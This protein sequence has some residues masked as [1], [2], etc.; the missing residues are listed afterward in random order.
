MASI[1]ALAPRIEVHHLTR[2]EGH[3]NIIVDIRDG[4]IQVCDLE[5]VEAPRYFEAMLRGRP[6]DQVPQLASRICG[7]CA[8]SHTTAS[9]GAIESAL[10]VQISPQTALLRHLNLCAEMLDSHLLHVY[11]LVAPDLIGTESVI[12]LALEKPELVSRALR[13][14]H[15]AGQICA[16]VG[17]RH[18]HPIAMTVGGFTHVPSEAELQALLC[19]LV[20]MRSDIESTVE[21]FAQLSFPSFERETEYVALQKEGGYGLEGGHIVSSDGGCWPVEQYRD[22]ATEHQV[23]YSTAKHARHGNQPFMVGALSRFNLNHK[24][25]RPGARE[26]AARLRLRPMCHNPFMISI[27]QVVEIVHFYEEALETI[28]Q[29][30]ALGIQPEEIFQPN[31]LSGEGVAAIEAPRGTLYHHFSLRDGAIAEAN[32]V[33]PTGQNLANIEADM[34]ALVPQ[35]WD[36]PTDEITLALEMLVRAYDPCISCSTHMVEV[37]FV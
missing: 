33:I 4:T 32:C 31:H 6:Y 28:R 10:S 18:T 27:A 15:V 29:L 8:V 12:P 3:G 13:M 9:L 17:G 26:A 16:A 11:L 22:V 7:I 5:I 35:I 30:L 2:I 19:Q 20:E 24:K 34:R 1:K 21:L 14:K 23:C 36:R 37:R 25:L